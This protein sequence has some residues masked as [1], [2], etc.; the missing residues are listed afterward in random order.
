MI[1]G[2]RNIRNNCKIEQ[3]VYHETNPGQELPSEGVSD[4]NSD[5]GYIARRKNN[6]CG[7]C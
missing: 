7:K 4:K 1:N 2:K 3:N 6:R 5:V